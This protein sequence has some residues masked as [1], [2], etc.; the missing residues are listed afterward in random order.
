M[1]KI[2]YL[3][4]LIALASCSGTVDPEQDGGQDPIIPEEFTAPFTLVADRTEVEAS[5]SDYV[6]FSLN[7]AYGRNVL[8]DRKALQSVNIVSEE[9]LRVPRL[10]DKARFIANGTYNFTARFKGQPCANTVKITASN[11][12]KYEK[13]HKN[14][15][16]YKCTGT[17]CGYCPSMT[18]AIE[19]MNDDAKAHSVELCWHGN[20]S[21][22]DAFAVPDSRYADCGNAL[23]A[24][25]STSGRTLGFP[26]VILDLE[27]VVTDR[28]ASAL[29]TGIWNLRADYPATCGIKVATAVNG[30]KMTV[31][32]EMTT[33]E[34]GEY[35]LGCAVLLND[36]YVSG[37]TAPDGKYTHIVRATTGNYYMYS[38]AIREVAKDASL[39]F[40][41][42]VDLS[43]LDPKNLS[44]VVFA[45]V[46]HEGGARI[47]NIVEVKAGESID[48]AYNE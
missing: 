39:K 44:V 3:S 34:G 43:N 8:E 14:V 29:E 5:G 26:T 48:Y 17:W 30:G 4:I 47:D 42:T 45:L 2:Q 7:D 16:L 31:N 20:G 13:Y 37:G 15:A 18:L 36:Q 32:A 28:A 35:D 40:D 24:E 33:S 41:Q 25:F 10:D 6:T 27:T 9:G 11:R 23:L 19:A 21:G 22:S 38:T 12:G 1:K 46:K